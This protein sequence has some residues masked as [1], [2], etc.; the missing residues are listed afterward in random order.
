[1]KSVWFGLAALSLFSVSAFAQAAEVHAKPLSDEDIKLMR[2]DLQKSKNQV[3]SDT[4]QFTT[5]ENTA[6][7]PI[8]KDYSSEQ[9][10]IADR[11]LKLIIDYAQHLDTMTDAKANELTER[12]FTI[13]DDTQNLRKKYYPKFVQALG[14]KR[15]AKFYQVDHRLT[16]MV[17]VQ[18]ASEVPLIP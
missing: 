1:M 13:E 16:M 6:F 4:M 11:R 7:W 8:Y 10:N 15:T 14:A 5:A 3:I 9:H 2:Q 12:S 18:L 17:D